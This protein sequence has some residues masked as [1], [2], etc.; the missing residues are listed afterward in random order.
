MNYIINNSMLPSR[1]KEPALNLK[2]GFENNAFHRLD[3][4]TKHLFSEEIFLFFEK[5]LLLC[6]I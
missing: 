1:R 6:G 2:I 4:E 5:Q 3:L